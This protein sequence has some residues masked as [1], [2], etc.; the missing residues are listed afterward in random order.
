[1]QTI[2]K[3]WKE[4]SLL[5]GQ[6]IFM[7]LSA[8]ELDYYWQGSMPGHVWIMQTSAEATKIMSYKILAQTETH[9]DEACDVPYAFGDSLH[10]SGIIS[11]I[12]TLEFDIQG[13]ITAGYYP[14]T[15]FEEKS[16]TFTFSE[17]I[18]QITG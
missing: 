16:G 3:D 11:E 12:R 5:L 18:T 9:G 14:N 15:K 6:H 8:K 13:T 17:R 1:M 10:I 4:A 7:S 2:I